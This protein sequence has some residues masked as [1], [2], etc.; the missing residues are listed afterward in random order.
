[1]RKAGNY[2]FFGNI[3]ISI[4]AFCLFW[5]TCI[6]IQFSLPLGL[7]IWVALATFFLYNFDS[8]LPSKLRYH[9]ELSPRKAWILAHR[10]VLAIAV[11]LAGLL[12]LYLSWQ[13]FVL[14]HFW[15][16]AHLA[17][18]SFFYSLPVIP[19]ATGFIPLRNVPLLKL[20]LIAYVWASVTVWLPLLAANVP[21]LTGK[22]WLLFLERFFFILPLTIIFDIRDVARDR[23]T[24]T[25]TLPQLVGVK[26]AK[27]LAFTF[28]VGYLLVVFLEQE[29]TN[30]IALLLSGVVYAGVIALTHE[31][32]SEYFYTIL[33]DGVLI[34]PLLLSLLL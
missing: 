12:L 34:L 4:C 6:R 15:L 14:A 23:T 22:G 1:L 13:A 33:G 29:D 19:T 24:A 21:V 27:L 3:F 32:R 20:F 5:A 9:S 30:Q 28:L 17:I 10:Q 25:L 7:G 31:N 26:R 11:V 8:L 16:L 18:I 2:F